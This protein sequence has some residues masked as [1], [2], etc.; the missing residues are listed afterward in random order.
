MSIA[1][2]IES[3]PAASMGKLARRGRDA[4]VTLRAQLYPFSSQALGTSPSSQEQ[5]KASSIARFYQFGLSVLASSF[6]GTAINEADD[7]TSLP[8]VSVDFVRQLAITNQLAAVAD[9]WEIPT[10]E[11]TWT[12]ESCRIRELVREY[13]EATHADY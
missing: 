10:I 4:A 6:I 13:N 1:I 7:S 3:V 2:P 8:A 11:H 5:T 9:E 12:A